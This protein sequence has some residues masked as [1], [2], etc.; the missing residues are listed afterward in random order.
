MTSPTSIDPEDP[1]LRVVASALARDDGLEPDQEILAALGSPWQ[2][3]LG[4]VYPVSNH[5]YQTPRAAWTFYLHRAHAVL[6]ELDRH[7]EVERHAVRP[8]RAPV[9]AEEGMDLRRVPRYLPEQPP[10]APSLA[11][12]LRS[13]TARHPENHDLAAECAAGGAEA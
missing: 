6:A 13:L 10:A 7:A 12:A 2:T 5:G 3:S 9:A 11:E 8:E 4:P 1:R